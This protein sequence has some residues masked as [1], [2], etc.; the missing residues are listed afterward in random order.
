[1]TSA[2]R[3][4]L[5]RL[6]VS[7]ALLASCSAASLACPEG[8]VAVSDPN[9]RLAYCAPACVDATCSCPPGRVSIWNATAG[10]AACAP[11]CGDGGACPSGLSCQ[12]CLASGD[13]PTCTVC[14]AACASV[15]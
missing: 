12:T 9:K 3:P 4:S 15:P 7:L 11:A 8:T 13:C 6:L 10:A 14:V 2:D 5:A 1:V